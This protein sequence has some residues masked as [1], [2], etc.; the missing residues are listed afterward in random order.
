MKRLLLVALII[1]GML[2]IVFAAGRG[3]TT[4]EYPWV[5]R[6]VAALGMG[7]AYYAK[8]DS[9]YAPFYNPAGLARINKGRVDIIPLTVGINTNIVDFYDEFNKTDTDSDAE[10]AKLLAGRVGNL[11]HAELSFY[12]GYTRK[13]FTIGVFG[14]TQVNAAPWNPITPELNLDIT[15]DA[16]VVFGMAGGFFD[17]RLQAGLAAR[18]QQRYSLQ[19]TYTV[20]DI[21]SGEFENIDY[22]YFSDITKNGWDIFFDLG[23]IYNISN[24]SLLQPRVALAV[25]NLGINSFGDAKELPWS[26]NF[27]V[28]ISPHYGIINTDIILDIRDITRNFNEDDDFVKR[29]NLGAEIRFFERIALR[30]GAHQGWLTMGAGLDLWLFRLDYAYYT[31]EIGAYAGQKKDTRHALEFVLGF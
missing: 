19:R 23:I 31:E 25:N 3:I 1:L 18:Y 6:S 7:D 14:A 11:Q 24:D 2:D 28:G 22:D 26:L 5:M 10:I 9:K 4:R 21:L 20:Q 12:P 16:G 17:D 8:S 27:S 30:G 29:I 15:A 13:N